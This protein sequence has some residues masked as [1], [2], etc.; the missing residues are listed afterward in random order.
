MIACVAVAGLGLAY[1]PNRQATSTKQPGVEPAHP[2]VSTLP[3]QVAWLDAANNLQFGTNDTVRWSEVNAGS[4][5]SVTADLRAAHIGLIRTWFFRQE[6]VDTGPLQTDSDIENRI[7]VV[8]SAGAVCLGELPDISNVQW[9]VQVVSYLGQRC[10]LYEIGNEP[11][12]PYQYAQEWKDLVP[13]LRAINPQARFFGPAATDPDALAAL[14]E[15]MKDTGV[16]PDGIT[17]H[18]YTCSS[19]DTAAS[20]LVSG[21]QAIQVAVARV[22]RLVDA[23]YGD[24]MPIGLTEWNCNGL[25]PTPQYCQDS[26]FQQQFIEAGET[27]IV[28]SGLSFAANFDLA[29]GNGPLDMFDVTAA[30]AKPKGFYYGMRAA[31]DGYRAAGGP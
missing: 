12:S 31:I 14:L 1:L 11:S 18:L 9:D 26:T 4:A 2:P 13:R 22:R 28:R 30:P 25:K 17:F 21:P 19:S 6:Y 20:C 5:P 27:A 7:D 24:G 15:A 23:L 3:G 29:N 8:E 16:R 10:D